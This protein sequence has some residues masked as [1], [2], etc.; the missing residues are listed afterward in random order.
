MTTLQNWHA[1]D[2]NGLLDLL[3]G[4]QYGTDALHQLDIIKQTKFYESQNIAQNL[5]LTKDDR[6]ID[7]GSGCGFIANH[8]APLVH[9]IDCVDISESFLK[10]NQKITGHH[11][12]IGYYNIP[13]GDMNKVP[14]ANAIYAVAVFIHFN[15]YDCY[16]YLQQCFNCLVSQGRLWFD[17]LNDQTLDTTT[18]LWQ[19]HT[20][21]Y[22]SDRNT[23]FINVHYNSITALTTIALQ[24]GFS[25]EKSFNENNHTFFLLRK[26]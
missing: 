14:Q 5:K 19:R 1:S 20:A 7:L 18:D 22:F 15:L 10:Y 21:R 4:K 9:H 17:F 25:L 6:V 24:L 3:V 26:P 2:L 11:S 8:I 13:F 12:N 23:T 16:L